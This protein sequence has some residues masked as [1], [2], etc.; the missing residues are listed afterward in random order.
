[1][2]ATGGS[3]GGYLGRWIASQTD[4]FAAIVNHAGVC[5]FQTQYASRRDAGARALAWAASRG[6][7]SREWTATTRCATPRA[8]ARPM[9]VIHGEKD[10]RVPHDA[11]ARDLQRL[12]G[13]EA[14]RPARLLPGREPLDPQAAEQP[15]LVRRVPRLARS[16]DRRGHAAPREEDAMRARAASPRAHRD[17]DGRLRLLASRDRSVHPGLQPLRARGAGDRAGSSCGRG[18]GIRAGNRAAADP[19]HPEGKDGRPTPSW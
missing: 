1:M 11:G 13:D 8:S 6:T 10:Y 19:L 5:D 4:R 7:T 3:Y 17:R 15:S 16:L 9:L 2:A 18:M 12:Q 14:P